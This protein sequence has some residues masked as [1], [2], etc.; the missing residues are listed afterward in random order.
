M[1][2]G[3]GARQVAT[4]V[5]LVMLMAAAFE[6]PRAEDSS[7]DLTDEPSRGALFQQFA[8]DVATAPEAEAFSLPYGFHFGRDALFDTD[9]T[10]RRDAI[11]GVDISHYEPAFPLTDLKRQNVA[12]VYAKA[13]QGARSRDKTFGAN[14]K[15]LGTLP[16]GAKIPRGAYHF[17]S[18]DPTMSGKDQADNFVDYVNSVGG[19]QSGDLPPAMDLEWDKTCEKCPDRWQ[20]NHRTAEQIVSTSLD[21]LTRVKERTGRTPMIY[22]NKSFLKDEHI[23]DPELARKLTGGYK[24]WIFDL[25]NRDRTIELPNPASNLAHVLWQFS[26]HGKLSGSYPHEFDVSVFKGTPDAFKAALTAND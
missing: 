19:F 17:L 6:Q 20:T 3:K 25:D 4:L 12:F 10:P 26:F 7:D 16:D 13:S 11:F 1:F 22:T 15:T 5:P 14:W 2:I 24:I 9:G 8:S 21:F 18:S 23:T